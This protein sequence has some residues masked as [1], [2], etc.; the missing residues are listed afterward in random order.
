M[1]DTPLFSKRQVAIAAFMGAPIAGALLMRKN[2]LA[3]ENHRAAT[4]SLIV[5]ILGSAALIAFM[6]F[7]PQN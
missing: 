6:F 4:G 5:G 7:L 2:Y 1:T 3:L